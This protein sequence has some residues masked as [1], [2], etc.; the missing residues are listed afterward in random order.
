[1]SQVT[2]PSDNVDDEQLAKPRPWA[3]AEI[4][5]F[6]LLVG[7]I[8]SLFD[9]A[10]FAVMWFLFKANT[11]A[12][13]GLFQTG[14]FVESLMTQTLII[15]VIRTNLIPFIQSRASWQ[16]TMTT[17]FIMAIGAYLPYSPLAPA[18]GFVPLPALFWPILLATLVCYVGLTQLVKS[19]LLKKS[20]I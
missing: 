7:P 20:W 13:A 16:L 18:L 6:I 5:R 9:Y 17:L 19:W 14:W 8:S 12:H 4:T 10:T 1:F 3:I 15:H 2:I 11:P